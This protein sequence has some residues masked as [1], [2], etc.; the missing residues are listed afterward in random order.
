[1]F[2]LQIFHNQGSAS[3][4]AKNSVWL[5]LGAHRLDEGQRMCVAFPATRVACSCLTDAD[6]CGTSGDN[7]FNVSICIN[8]N[9]WAKVFMYPNSISILLEIILTFR[10]KKA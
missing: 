2:V 5:G 4:S 10:R 7:N 6:D 9:V 1:M 8:I 3:S